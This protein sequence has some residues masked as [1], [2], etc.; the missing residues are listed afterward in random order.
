MS[1]INLEFLKKAR[2]WISDGCIL[3]VLYASCSKNEKNQICNAF[4]I[5]NPLISH[6]SSGF[7]VS[8]A[9]F[10]FGHLKNLDADR[11]LLLSILDDA[12]AGRIS[13]ADII[14]ELPNYEPQNSHSS[15]NNR[16]SWF[17]PL[18]LKLYG[19]RDAL[20]ST[21]ELVQLDDELR[22]SQIPFDGVNDVLGHL[23]LPN[24]IESTDAPY[25]EII[26][27]PPVDLVLDQTVLSKNLLKVTLHAH[28]QFNETR[29]QLTIRTLP[30][31][32]LEN[33]SDITSKIEWSLL[34]GE[35]KVGVAEVNLVESDSVLTMLA[36]DN[37]NVRRQWIIDKDKARNLRLL[38]ILSFDADLS[39][40]KASIFSD[41]D[42]RN[43]E[44]GIANLLFIHGFNPCQPVQSEAPDLVVMTPNGK[45][46]IVECTI[47]IADF[48]NK[49]GKLVD[50]RGAL[51]KALSDQ[52]T[53]ID[54]IA[55]LICRLPNDQIS[56]KKDEPKDNK[57]ILLSA[58]HL[59]DL[60]NK[61][62]GP[63]NPDTYIESEL[64][65]FQP[66]T[67]F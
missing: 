12:I 3:D 7:L 63:Y 14:I 20:H 61:C 27:N 51:K 64:G 52:N 1:E 11:G 55:V 39:K 26:I 43:F 24:I 40:T 35:R 22:I 32:L 25:L 29:I 42:S 6:S 59:L 67:I 9:G 47:K 19:K 58:D 62:H 50:R 37:H 8:P 10:Q 66:A 36:I 41:T 30:G 16:G 45:I 54:P 60:F 56:A 15:M 23:G 34:E 17:S 65:N 33:R 49:I 18:H 53:H 2:S 44:K 38:P 5:I 13:V 4:I 57:V 31:H 21:R 48:S 46:I 28:E